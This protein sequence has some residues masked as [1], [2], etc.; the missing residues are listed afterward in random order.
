MP[1]N[2]RD[3]NEPKCAP[4]TASGI[5]AFFPEYRLTPFFALG[6]AA[7]GSIAAPALLADALTGTILTRVGLSGLT[8]L[9]WL[10]TLAVFTYAM[11]ACLVVNDALKV[12]LIKWRV[13]TAIA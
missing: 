7:C 3:E 6:L 2:R 11:V 10:Q 5:Y 1:T 4:V 13:P 8:P 9:P 12:A